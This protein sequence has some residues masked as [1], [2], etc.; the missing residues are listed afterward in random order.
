MV[1]PEQVKAWLRQA[2]ADLNAANVEAEG[3]AECHRR[4]WLQQAYEK[5]IKSLALMLWNGTDDQ[6]RELERLF[7]LQHS[8]LKN[9]AGAASPL[10]KA[11]F[12]LDR[13]VRVFVRRLD[14]AEMLLKI[15][16]TSPTTRVD[17]VS[18]RY[19]FVDGGAY[20]APTDFTGWDV[21]QGNR[22]GGIAAVQRLLQ[23]VKEELRTFARKPK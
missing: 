11:L 3:L 22:M 17:E 15:D 14:N 4:Y 7:L 21:Y 23:T 13:E 12:L 9:L 2:E 20:V 6:M 1:T 18:Y 16:A 19:P 8:P 5:G 10:S